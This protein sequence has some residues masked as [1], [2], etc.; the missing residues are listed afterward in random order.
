MYYTI[1][2]PFCQLLLFLPFD[3]INKMKNNF[4][5]NI[6]NSLAETQKIIPAINSLAESIPL[7][8]EIKF[9]FNLALNELL[10]NIVSYAFDDNNEHIINI[11]ISF[12][13]DCL[14]AVI[15]DDGKE[16]NPLEYPPPDTKKPLDERSIGG[17]GV[18]FVKELMDKVK[19]ERRSNQ[20]ILTVEKKIK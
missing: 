6:K 15:T 20:N 5:L 8:N 19:Y 14:K 4:T 2:T 7:S 13:K 11:Q 17:L 9:D 3:K 12:D 16:F 1:I 10:T 18:F